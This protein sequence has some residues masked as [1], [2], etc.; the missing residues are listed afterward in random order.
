MKKTNGMK[1]K[2]KHEDCT[3]VASPYWVF[4]VLIRPTLSY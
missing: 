4:D 2:V 1:M 3:L